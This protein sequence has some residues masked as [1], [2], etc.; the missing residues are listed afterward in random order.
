MWEP[1]PTSPVCSFNEWDPLE[2][3]I[4]GRVDGAAF[5][6]WRVI[7]EQTVPPGDWDR[8]EAAVGAVGAAYPAA[9]I[10]AAERCL[11]G[12]VRRLE[13]EGVRVR[14]PDLVDSTRP[15]AS[16][17]WAVST[18]FCTA[19]PRDPFLVVGDEI[20]ETPMADRSRYFEALAYR[21]LFTEYLR[22]GARWTSAPRPRLADA[23]YV[24]GHAHPAEGEPMR[25]VLTEEEPVFDAA[26]IVRCGR[27]LFVQR[28]HV[29]NETGILWLR[30]H[31][32][33]RF[34]VHEL[35]TR[36]PEAIH[37][38]TTFMPLCPGKV[39]VSPEYV[40]V[41]R[42]P[43]M[44]RSWEVRACPEPVPTQN[45]PLRVI[46]RWGAVNVLMLDE[47]RIIVE[48]R[49]TP[50]IEMLRAWGFDPIPCEFEG[51]FPFM[52]SFHCAT[53]DVRRRGTLQSYF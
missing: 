20:I 25:Y 9:M 4:V 29:T 36:N 24:K 18:G 42:L 27:D 19:N 51:Y 40:D 33:P 13:S 14:R 31:L 3:V 5:P 15:F 1:D 39:L 53:L 10:S 30:R 23:L 32:G 2:E 45:D 21:R 11:E 50:L 41:E 46:S 26:D 47:R 6:A 16:P 28:S 34:R 52:G 48:A 38:D 8:I 37:I 12:F 17:D 49:Q 43:P 7:N 22:G 35:E 44:F